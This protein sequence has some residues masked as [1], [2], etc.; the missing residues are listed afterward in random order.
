MT[1]E[2]TQFIPRDTAQHPGTVQTKVQ[3]VNALL[4]SQDAILLPEIGHLDPPER[5]GNV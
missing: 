3:T 4:P 2:E 5:S 1:G